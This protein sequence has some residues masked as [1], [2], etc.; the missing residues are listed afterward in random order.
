MVATS[1]SLRGSRAGGRREGSPAPRGA[2]SPD[3]TSSMARGR[4]VASA[5]SESGSFPP[6]H[7]LHAGRGAYKLPFSTLLGRVLNSRQ[8]WLSTL[9]LGGQ[10]GFAAD[11]PWPQN[12]APSPHP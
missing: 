10:N 3:A 9:V 5:G 2:P 12:R 11:S 1:A 6:S 4:A 7:L 8:P